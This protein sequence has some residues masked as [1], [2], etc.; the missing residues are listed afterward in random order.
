MTGGRRAGAVGSPSAVLFDLDGT[1]VDS[2]PDIAGALNVCLAD[3][4]LEPLPVAAIR[5]MIDAG[6]ERLLEAAFGLRGARLTP[7]EAEAWAARF[8]VLYEARV[9]RDTVLRPGAADLVGL[10]SEAGIPLGVCTNKA[11]GLA[12]AVLDGLGLGDRIAALVGPGENRPKKPD[13]AILRAALD[14]LRARHDAAILVGDNAADVAAARAANIA[15]VLVEGG[16]T[17]VPPDRLGADRVFTGLDD[18][19][20]VRHLLGLRPDGR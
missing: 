4:G 10:L 7:Q 5:A 19:R 20:L 1:L 11:E 9:V 3:A 17:V 6:I 15:V 8:M 16:H 18:P 14:R 13:P 2:V 12:R